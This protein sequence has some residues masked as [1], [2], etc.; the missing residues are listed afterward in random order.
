MASRIERTASLAQS[1]PKANSPGNSPGGDPPASKYPRGSREW[2]V[3]RTRD[4][5]DN[6]RLSA[7]EQLKAIAE[8]RSLE[9]FQGSGQF[10]DEVERGKFMEQWDRAIASVANLRELEKRLLRDHTVRQDLMRALE[11][12]K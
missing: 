3:E 11:E 8:L 6:P 9:E 12:T 5:V 4:L 10:D 1:A 7:S 2:L